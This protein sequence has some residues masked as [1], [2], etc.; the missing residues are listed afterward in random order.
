MTRQLVPIVYVSTQP[1]SV[2]R[3]NSVVLTRLAYS[4]V[5][6]RSVMDAKLRITHVVLATSGMGID[7]HCEFN[8]LAKHF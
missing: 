7:W 8:K 1:Q 6:S 3:I 5:L 4:M 2:R